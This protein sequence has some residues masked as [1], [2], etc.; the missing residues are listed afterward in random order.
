MDLLVSIHVLNQKLSDL[1]SLRMKVKTLIDRKNELKLEFQ[2]APFSLAWLQSEMDKEEI[3]FQAAEEKRKQLLAMQE[4]ERKI[5]L[6]EKK[7]QERKNKQ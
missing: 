3:K 1:H 4:K 6:E 5:A 7:A 2:H